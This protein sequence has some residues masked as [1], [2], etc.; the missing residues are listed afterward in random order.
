MTILKIH[1]LIRSELHCGWVILTHSWCFIGACKLLAAQT[2]SFTL[3]LALVLKVVVFSK[4]LA[5]IHIW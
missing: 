1:G 5:F 2:H 3:Q 4:L